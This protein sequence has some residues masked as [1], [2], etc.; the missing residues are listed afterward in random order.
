MDAMIFSNGPPAP[1]LGIWTPA[2]VVEH[3]AL[4]YQY[5]DELVFTKINVP[6]TFVRHAPR[7]Q[8]ARRAEGAHAQAQGLC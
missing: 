4:G 3:R 1:I 5:D 8:R 7:P 2:S 6:M